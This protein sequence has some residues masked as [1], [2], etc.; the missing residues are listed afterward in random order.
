M[1]LA[2][3]LPLLLLLLCSC[4]TLLNRPKQSFTVYTT[5]PAKVSIEGQGIDS[6]ST[7][8][9]TSLERSLS[10]VTVI[11]ETDS[12]IKRVT[13]AAHRSWAHMSNAFFFPGYFVDKQTPRK[14]GYPLNL[15]IDFGNTA[16][17]YYFGRPGENRE[18]NLLKFT[19]L[20]LG[21]LHN[22]S[23]E[24]AY[25]RVISSAFGTQASASMLLPYSTLNLFAGGPSFS[26]SGFRA[27]AEQRYY[28]KKQAPI[29]IY[30]AFETD[31]LKNRYQA[32]EHFT[33]PAE[34]D[35]NNSGQTLSYDYGYADTITVHK[36]FW[37][38]HFKFG[39]QFI[40][41]G[42]YV[43]MFTGAGLR[44]KKVVFYNRINPADVMTNKNH[45][46]AWSYFRQ[47]GTVYAP[48]FPVN[49]RIGY[50]F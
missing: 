46:D 28:I 7:V 25:E 32:I 31:H 27:S 41:R 14:F 26:N 16:Q 23:L 33:P 50:R 12:T 10:T 9:K 13:V 6:N 49:F 39:R 37:G 8:H 40:K 34:R 43:D 38:F 48:A 24:F 36:R 5:A 22:P 20:K 29:G 1:Q 21:G 19:P 18:K 17:P 15:T 3:L 44:I 2:K 30:V 45:H 35:G 42:F 4:A 47:D 11:A